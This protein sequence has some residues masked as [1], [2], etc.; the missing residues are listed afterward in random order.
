MNNKEFIQQLSKRTNSTVDNT[1]K[2][3]ESLIDEMGLVFEEGES[4][5]FNGFGTFEVKKRMERVMIRPY[6]QKRILVPPKLVLN[7]KPTTAVKDKLKKKG[8]SAND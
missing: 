6:D 5:L 7:F 2:M 3:I 1:Q 8:D 4:V